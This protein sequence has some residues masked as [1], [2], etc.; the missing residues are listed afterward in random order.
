MTKIIFNGRVETTITAEKDTGFKRNSTDLWLKH[1][2]FKQQPCNFFLENANMP[3]IRTFYINQASLS[4]K[5]NRK[6]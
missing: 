3:E 1:D 4:Y 2:Y 6:I 5:D